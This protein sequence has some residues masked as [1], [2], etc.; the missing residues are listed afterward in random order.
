MKPRFFINET[1]Y[2]PAAKHRPAYVEPH[3]Q[4]K[5]LYW[6]TRRTRYLPQCP[7]LFFPSG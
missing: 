2:A 3:P 4:M 7:P 1:A 6:Q 5:S